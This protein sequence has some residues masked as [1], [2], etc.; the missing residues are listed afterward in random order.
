MKRNNLLVESQVTSDLWEMVHYNKNTSN[1]Q[2]KFDFE[3][4]SFR[5]NVKDI[6][7]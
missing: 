1:I 5:D 7:G 3:K 2:G 4:N 6:D